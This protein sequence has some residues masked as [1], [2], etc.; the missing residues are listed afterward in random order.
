MQTSID[1]QPP[2]RPRHLK[3]YSFAV[4]VRVARKTRG[5]DSDLRLGGYE[6]SLL[7]TALPRDISPYYIWVLRRHKCQHLVVE[8]FFI[9]NVPLKMARSAAYGRRYA[10]PAVCPVYNTRITPV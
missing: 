3:C 9:K 6:P 4:A 2:K 5:Q 7:T 10:L 1:P 8:N